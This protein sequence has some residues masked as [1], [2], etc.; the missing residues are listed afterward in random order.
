MQPIGLTVKQSRNKYA[1]LYP[2][3][4][5]V[6]HQC[7]DCGKLSINRIASDDLVE[8]IAAIYRASLNLDDVTRHHLD[9]A[10]IR[11]LL[12]GDE[13]IVTYQLYGMYNQG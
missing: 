6:I 5:M 1:G 7:N 2:G 4:L 8:V 3:E 10:G 12:D 9:H 13:T 11:P